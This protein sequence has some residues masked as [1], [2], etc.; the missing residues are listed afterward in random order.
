M[1]ELNGNHEHRNLVCGDIFGGPSVRFPGFH[2]TLRTPFSRLSS[3][4]VIRTERHL[5]KET[6][7]E[8]FGQPLLGPTWMA[9][10]SVADSR[11]APRESRGE[12]H[13]TETRH[14]AWHGFKGVVTLQ[15]LIWRCCPEVSPRVAPWGRGRHCPAGPGWPFLNCGQPCV[16]VHASTSAPTRSTESQHH[17]RDLFRWWD[18]IIC[19]CSETPFSVR[20]PGTAHPL[21]GFSKGDSCIT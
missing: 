7:R 21:G 6:R 3:V 11:A 2:L 1:L 9:R 17:C 14:R 19:W 20:E 12:W 15:V 8:A 4:H 13:T 18:R 5:S 10:W 16:T